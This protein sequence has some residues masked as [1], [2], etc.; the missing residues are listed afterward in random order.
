MESCVVSKRACPV[1]KRACPKTWLPELKLLEMDKEVILCPT[2][3]LTDSIINAVQRLLKKQFP[4]INGFQDTC[5]G[6]VYNFKIL[7]GDIIQI[8]FSPN[9]IYDGFD[10]SKC[11]S[12]WQQIQHGINS[13]IHT[14]SFNFV[15]K[16]SP[17]QTTIHGYSA[18]GITTIIV[19]TYKST[20]YHAA[21]KS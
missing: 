13:S 12:V 8:L 20:H 17:N 10:S 16:S 2:G 15:Y 11:C 4:N 7:Q 14:N 19:I 6:S 21:F 9:Y 1:S 3:W 5:L 18:T